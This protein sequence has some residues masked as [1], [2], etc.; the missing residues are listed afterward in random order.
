MKLWGGRFAK[1][2]AELLEE[3]QASITFDQSLAHYDLLGSMAH[4]RMLGKI[5]VLSPSETEKIIN[6]LQELASE[7]EAGQ[8]DFSIKAEDIHLNIELL[9]T[10]KIGGV[11]KK[12]HTGRSRNDQ[13]ALDLRMYVKDQITNLQE[14]LINLLTTLVDLADQHHQAIMPGYTHLQIAQPVTLGHHLLAYAE[15]FKRDYERLQDCLR[16]VDVLPLGA[17]ALAGTTYPLDREMV[18]RE[19]GFSRV[20]ENSMDSVSDRDFVIEFLGDLALIMMHLSRFCEEI[21]FWA[22]QE[23]DFIELDDAFSTGSSMMPQKK[24]PDVVELI[25]GKTA[26]VYGDLITLLTMLKGLPL[27]YNKDMQEDKEALFDGVNTVSACL[28]IFIPFLKTI[29]FKK[30][31][32][33]AAAGKGFSNATDLADYFVQQGLSFREAHHLVG[34]LVNYCLAKERVLTDL[35]LQELRQFVPQDLPV[36]ETVFTILQLENVV[37]RRSTYGGTSPEQV[38]K[39]VQR[40]RDFLA[41]LRK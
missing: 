18:A 14:L 9:L 16:R 19:L 21:I 1:E 12:M 5:G 28:R 22:S 41:T 11:A 13:I 7:I 39:A 27:T 23:V 25:R 8:V 32:M 4:V 26:R 34:Q 36:E 38:A 40:M 35:S 17:G 10:E 29:V 3:F 33:K 30:E 15:M 24:N 2:T 6:G 31:K 20:S 37:K